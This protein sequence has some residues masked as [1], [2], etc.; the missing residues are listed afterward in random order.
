MKC[1]VGRGVRLTGTAIEYIA[2]KV[3]RKAGNFQTDLFPPC[4]AP[5]AASKF[6]EWWSGI[7]RDPIRMEIQ[8][9]DGNHPDHAT[10]V[11]RRST[12]M[13]KLGDKSGAAQA[14]VQASASVSSS[15][16]SQAQQ[17]EINQLKAKVQ[18][19]TNQVTELQQALNS[20]TQRLEDSEAQLSE[21][22]QENGEIQERLNAVIEENQRLKYASESQPAYNGE[23]Q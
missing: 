13:A 11:Q 21:A 19:L 14:T 12:F 15:N 6:E 16:E 17:E 20:T 8:P 2:F 22:R 23:A 1:E 7:D 3:P 10:M 9:E 5:E 18:V 4:R